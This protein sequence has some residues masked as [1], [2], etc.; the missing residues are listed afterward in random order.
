MKST[1]DINPRKYFLYL[2]FLFFLFL[3]A[4]Q[5]IF[6]HLLFHGELSFDFKNIFLSTLFSL[7]FFV[8]LVLVNY[9]FSFTP[10]INS[11]LGY[12]SGIVNRSTPKSTSIFRFLLSLSLLMVSLKYIHL[13]YD[14]G[15]LSR[16]IFPDISAQYPK[17]IDRLVPFMD[18]GQGLWTAI[19]VILFFLA[20][21]G[22]ATRVTLFAIWLL[23]LYLVSHIEAMTPHW[24]HG[25]NP[26]FLA[27]IPVL[28]RDMRGEWYIG[29][30]WNDKEGPSPYGPLF[31]S[32]VFLAIFYFGAFVMK[33]VWGGLSWITSEH[34][35]NSLDLA[36]SD[37]R[38]VPPKPEYVQ[39]VQDSF[40]LTTLA[41][42]GHLAM[43]AI[44]ILIIFS[45][46]KPF[47]RA[48]E[49]LVFMAGVALLWAFMGHLW[50]WYWWMLV[51]TVFIDWDWFLDKKYVRLNV[52]NLERFWKS[53]QTWFGALPGY[54]AVY[55]L[56]TL[57]LFI[58]NKID[59]YP[60]FDSLRFYAVPYDSYPYT[61]KDQS[62]FSK[63]G[64]MELDTSC[65]LDRNCHWNNK[66]L[67]N[68]NS[69][70]YSV[71]SRSTPAQNAAMLEAC[72]KD[73]SN[74][75]C[76]RASDQANL[77]VWSGVFAYNDGKGLTLSVLG[78]KV[79]VFQKE[80]LAVVLDDEGGA[81][82]TGPAAS[83][84]SDIRLLRLDRF[85]G[86]LVETDD[87][88]GKRSCV[89]LAETTLLDGTK[90]PF[91]VRNDCKW[92]VDA[93]NT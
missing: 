56:L 78:M 31:F 90:L 2:G 10:T 22:L 20:A 24:S 66:V 21:T 9:V 40:L 53:T 59:A 80:W 3:G 41:S 17:V 73:Q 19:A 48:F 71:M 49:G 38:N 27:G 15:V 35:I 37:F 29:R 61:T 26:I 89:L 12:L 70:A 39:A 30:I 4:F 8:L 23:S 44:P 11:N 91:I 28:F 54:I 34:F 88:S 87:S 36:W 18:I 14:E 7:G 51:G 68:T 84:V 57:T 5:P 62:Y 74:T 6:I 77:A 64:F 86:D 67:G 79:A 52:E 33:M 60:F 69:I 32:Q 47:A 58:P 93:D 75:F 63:S 85:T 50:P 72:L 55:L 81:R 25:E 76:K 13:I 16:D 83:T 46:H 42:W 92:Q 82:A 65:G 43:Q 1:P 45:A